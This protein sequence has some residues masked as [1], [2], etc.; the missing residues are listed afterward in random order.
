[1]FTIMRTFSFTATHALSRAAEWHPCHD[2][3]AHSYEITIEWQARDLG[4]QG[5]VLD[6]DGV[7]AVGEDIAAY[8]DQRDLNVMFPGM[9]PTAELLAQALYWR[10]YAW[11]WPD[12]VCLAGVSLTEQPGVR[13]CYRPDTVPAVTRTR[14]AQ[15]S[16]PV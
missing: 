12:G 6:F 11:H 2:P 13:A 15:R 5:L 9:Q 4:A 8:L 3:H 14:R 1:M 16:V 10:W 7:A